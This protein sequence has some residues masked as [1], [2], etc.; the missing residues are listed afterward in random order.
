VFRRGV[1]RGTS[2]IRL[3]FWGGV[4]LT[5]IWTV[6]SALATFSMG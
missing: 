3:L 1:S 4:A 6:F 5:F 2:M